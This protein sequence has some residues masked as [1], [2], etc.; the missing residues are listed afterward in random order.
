MSG[1]FFTRYVNQEDI[2]LWTKT[3]ISET[4]KPLSS[5]RV[6]EINGVLEDWALE[7]IFKVVKQRRIF[8]QIEELRGVSCE[9]FEDR[10]YYDISKGSPAG[11]FIVRVQDGSAVLE[12]V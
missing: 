7:R 11:K 1:Y 6:R 10:R 8:D 12:K 4:S 9:E 2:D 3:F 5:Q